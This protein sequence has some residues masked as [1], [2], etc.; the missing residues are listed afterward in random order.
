MAFITF[1]RTCGHRA[2]DRQIDVVC[3]ALLCADDPRDSARDASC[4]PDA[5]TWGH[6][7]GRG[8][9]ELTLVAACREE[10]EETS[11]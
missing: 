7:D 2:S 8:E 10:D 4:S 6:L 9:K 5:R 1:R 3:D 11:S